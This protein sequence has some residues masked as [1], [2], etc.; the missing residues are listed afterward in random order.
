MVVIRFHHPVLEVCMIYCVWS[1]VECL[2][3]GQLEKLLGLC[4]V[5]IPPKTE[6]CFEI[7]F[8]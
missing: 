4:M 6:L 2:W 1:I 8:H 7:F 3:C 5:L